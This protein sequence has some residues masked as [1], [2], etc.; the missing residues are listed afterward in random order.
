MWQAHTDAQQWQFSREGQQHNGVERELLNML[1]SPPPPSHDVPPP[2]TPQ[3]TDLNE[4]D[5]IITTIIKMVPPQERSRLRPLA[6]WKVFEGIVSAWP[7]LIAV[8][9]LVALMLPSTSVVVVWSGAGV[10]LFTFLLQLWVGTKAFRENML[11]DM[12]IQQGLRLYLADYLRRLPLGFFTRRDAGTIDGLFTTTLMYL[13][14]RT[15]LSALVSAVLAPMLLFLVMLTQDWRLA[16]ALVISVVPFFLV[17]SRFLHV[18]REVWQEQSGARTRANSRMVE[19]IQGINIIRAFNLSGERFT[20]FERAIEAYREASTRT[21]TR[22]VPMMVAPGLVLELGFALFLMLGAVFYTNETLSTPTFLLFLVLGAGFYVPFLA[23][24]D[25]LA[26]MRIIQNSVRNIN[27]FLQTPT[28]PEP[29]V[30]KHP[31][32]FAIDFKDVSFGYGDSEETNEKVLRVLEGVNIHIPERSFTALVG[33]SGSGKTTITNLIARFWD[34]TS[35]TVSIGGVDVREMHPDDL[36][37]QI[38][39]VFQDVYLFNDTVF[40]NIKVGNPTATR[41][42]VFA[43]ARAARCHEFIVEMPAGYDTM[44]GEGGATLSGGQRQRISI[45][46]AILKDA[47]IVL[48]DEATASIDPE[49]ESLIQQAFD[50]LVQHKTL[51]VIAHR[52]ATVQRADQI[53]V[54]NGGRILQRGT[55]EELIQQDGLYRHFWDE[56]QK[57]R[58]W[59]LCAAGPGTM[60]PAAPSDCL[61]DR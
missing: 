60:P 3:Y 45:A 13:E 61:A 24:A 14:T 7:G 10:L 25:M 31:R 43:A 57:A 36:L 23:F 11:L 20:Q 55:H 37:A 9:I 5:N 56:R 46:R 21:I 47:P 4:D 17:I 54:L 12:E 53:I 18:F 52:L 28:L 1:I 38:T 30:P 29:A 15:V 49:N 26:Y 44:V 22:I 33:P 48:L 59:K 41:E 34:A 6:G 58:G 19:Y 39:M 50:V 35:G 40:N 32:G 8:A 51:V 42:Q 16:L 27:A 2:S